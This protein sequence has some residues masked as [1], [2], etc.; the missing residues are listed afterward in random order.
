MEVINASVCELLRPIWY[1]IC[2]RVSPNFYTAVV[3]SRG[4][5]EPVKNSNSCI[6]ALSNSVTPN[7]GRPRSVIAPV[8]HRSG[9]KDISVYLLRSDSREVYRNITIIPFNWKRI[10]FIH[11]PITSS[12]LRQ[13]RDNITGYYR[14]RFRERTWMREGYTPSNNIINKSVKIIGV[15]ELLKAFSRVGYGG[16]IKLDCSEVAI[17]SH[18]YTNMMI[19]I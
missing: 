12:W 16:R 11:M 17:N 10:H 13:F 1:P 9:V 4:S 3:L 19:V 14:M 7:V 6:F 2:R 5:H 18:N 15:S 8:S